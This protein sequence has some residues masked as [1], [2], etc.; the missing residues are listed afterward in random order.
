MDLHRDI[1]IRRKEG[2]SAYSPR[3]ASVKLVFHNRRTEVA[4]EEAIIA[5]EQ[6]NNA[7]ETDSEVCEEG[8]QRCLPR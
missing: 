6:G 1:D 3:S 4:L 7:A 8:L 5:I 2:S